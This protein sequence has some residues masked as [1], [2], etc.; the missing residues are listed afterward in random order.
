VRIDTT[1]HEVLVPFGVLLPLV[2]HPVADSVLSYALLALAVVHLVRMIECHE[3]EH[4]VIL[5]PV[6]RCF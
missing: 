1:G 2:L 3:F 4:A 5:F 6:L